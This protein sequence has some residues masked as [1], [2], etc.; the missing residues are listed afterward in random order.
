MHREYVAGYKLELWRCIAEE[1]E[2]VRKLKARISAIEDEIKAGKQQRKTI[3]AET[4]KKNHSVTREQQGY[5]PVRCPTAG[6]REAVQ[7]R[8]RDAGQGR[9]GVRRFQRLE[10]VQDGWASSLDHKQN[11]RWLYDKITMIGGLFKGAVALLKGL[12]VLA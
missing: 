11:L 1:A 10:E 5:E 6:I 9:Q 8:H 4:A 12:K 3:D 7:G 2:E